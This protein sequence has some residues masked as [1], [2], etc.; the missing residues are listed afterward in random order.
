[1][2]SIPLLI[3]LAIST[4]IFCQQNTPV[5]NTEYLKKSKTQKKN[6]F[7]M[8][9]GGAALFLTGIVIPK[10]EL[11]HSGFLGDDYKNDGIKGGLELTGIISMLVSIPL[12]IASS[13]NKKK[14][15]SVSFKNNPSQQIQRGSFVN[16]SVP[17]LTFKIHL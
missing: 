6:A 16:R 5:I 4:N 8:L 10:G 2:K 15:M 11:V 14:A 17:S 7:I 3:M 12:F 13:K 9:G 1:M